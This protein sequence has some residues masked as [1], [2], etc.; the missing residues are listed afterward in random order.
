MLNKNLIARIA[1]AMA[2][3]GLAAVPLSANAQSPK[4]RQDHAREDRNTRIHQAEAAR[5]R[6]RKADHAQAARERSIQAQHA[7]EAQENRDRAIRAQQAKNASIART[8][9]NRERQAR[10]AQIARSRSVQARQAEL[11]RQRRI[12]AER[13]QNRNWSQDARNR[14]I[15]D[16]QARERALANERLRIKRNEAL[17]RARRAHGGR[18][19]V[20]HNS[21]NTYRPEVIYR[22]P[23]TTR[24]KYVY[25]NQEPRWYPGPP[26][27]EWRS[28][29][30]ISGGTSLLDLLRNDDR[31]VFPGNQ[32]ALY[33]YDQFE[34][35]R[36]SREPERR[37]RYTYFSRPFI[38]R[39]GYRYDRVTVN[40]HG[41]HYYRFVRR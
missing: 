9:S 27:N 39:N 40:Q 24:Y 31:L 18:P 22:T 26:P 14:S 30:N 34:Q 3:A 35:D 28:I 36:Y 10:D 5:A 11:A 6:T 15:H 13:N 12:H 29:A 7:R 23:P 16:R 37:L 25:V 21:Y 38:Y 8:Q 2:V 1:A 20:I 41:N 32:G 17:E 4:S 19:L 33:S